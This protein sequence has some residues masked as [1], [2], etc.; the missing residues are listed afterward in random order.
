MVFYTL[1]III[2][3]ETI[4]CDFE[5]IHPF[6][7]DFDGTFDENEIQNLLSIGSVKEQWRESTKLARIQMKTQ[8]ILPQ[9]F[10]F[11]V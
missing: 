1:I 6:C 5:N 9:S 4:N 2:S 11:T 10:S 8:S 3:V 7:W